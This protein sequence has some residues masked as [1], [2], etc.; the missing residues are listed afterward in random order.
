MRACPHPRTPLSPHE[1]TMSM[2]EDTM[3]RTD[4]F[5]PCFYREV[6]LCELFWRVVLWYSR[7]IEPLHTSNPD[8]Q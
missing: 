4:A 2:K 7:D 8:P 1:D 6:S 5:S 3:T